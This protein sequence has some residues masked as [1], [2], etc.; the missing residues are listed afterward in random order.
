MLINVCIKVSRERFT[1]IKCTLKVVLI[2]YM[3]MM[4]VVS[5]ENSV[6]EQ[7]SSG[8]HGN[9]DTITSPHDKTK[10]N[11]RFITS[12]PSSSSSLS[13]S[14]DTNSLTSNLLSPTVT[15]RSPPGVM[16]Q[17][18][19]IP[20]AFPSPIPSPQYPFNCTNQISVVQ[21]AAVAAS[22]I[23]GV[24]STPPSLHQIT[25]T[26]SSSAFQ[27]PSR[28]ASGVHPGT[29]SSSVFRVP[30]RSHDEAFVSTSEPSDIEGS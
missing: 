28:E 10:N 4:F 12:S 7:S 17:S 1:L 11:H 22:R 16:W 13:S 15:F 5:L 26:V 30:K 6:N 19:P 3:V 23:H 27:L 14:C 20:L 2:I 29:P 21:T 9:D 18:P 24:S 8:N 25:Q